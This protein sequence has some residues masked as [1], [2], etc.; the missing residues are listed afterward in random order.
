MS[1]KGIFVVA[2]GGRYYKNNGEYVLDKE[3]AYAFLLWHL[4]DRLANR[5][6]GKVERV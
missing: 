1:F 3:D 5:I 4:A 2:K 6:G